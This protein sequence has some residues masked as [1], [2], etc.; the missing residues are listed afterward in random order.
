[1]INTKKIIYDT[2]EPVFKEPDRDEIQ[3]IIHTL[4][5]NKSLGEDNIT[6]LLKLAEAPQI[7]QLIRS[8][9]NNEVILKDWNLAIIFPIFKKGNSAKVKN[10][11]GIILLDT[12]YKVLS[13]AILN[14]VKIYTADIIGEYQCG[15]MRGKSTTDHIFTI[16]SDY[17]EIL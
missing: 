8:I 10:Y 5:N 4:K 1:M 6:E 2:V 14:R 15:F 17:G 12:C 13:L 11:W 9:C 16:R 3:D 7:Q